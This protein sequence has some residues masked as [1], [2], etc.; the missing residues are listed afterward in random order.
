M[1]GELAAGS[2]AMNDGPVG[3]SL[4]LD[5]SQ[6]ESALSKAAGSTDRVAKLVDASFQK[7]AEKVKASTGKTGEVLKKM[8]ESALAGFTGGLAAG[9]VA[10]VL[11]K[12]GETGGQALK[13]LAYGVRTVNMEGLKMAA[14]VGA[15]NDK[16]ARA[17]K[18]DAERVTSL[19]SVSDKMKELERQIAKD[20]AKFEALASTSKYVAKQ[21]D[22]ASGIAS[23]DGWW[24]TVK[25]DYD[26]VTDRLKGDLSLMGGMMDTLRGKTGDA[27]EALA[28]LKDPL[29]NPEFTGALDKMTADWDLLLNNLDAS[30]IELGLKKL[31]QQFGATDAQMAK[32]VDRGRAFEQA[33]GLHKF[34]ES[35]EDQVKALD[36][37]PAEA[38]FAAI[39]K[40]TKLPADEA[41][42]GMER[43]RA[44]E[45]TIELTKYFDDL[46]RRAGTLDLSPAEQ[47][48]A[49][50]GYRIKLTADQMED[51][52]ERV[53]LFD[54]LAKGVELDKQFGEAMKGLDLEAKM[55]G[56]NDLQKKLLEFEAKGFGGD[57][58]AQLKARL[59][60]NAKLQAA[61]EKPE[62]ASALVAGGRDTAN[63][64]AAAQAAAMRGGVPG[65]AGQQAQAKQVEQN[66]MIVGL[67]KTLTDQGA[68]AIEVQ[69]NYEKLLREQNQKAG[70]DGGLFPIDG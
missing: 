48:F 26:K 67:L 52:L 53:R 50:L 37:S 40:A 34:F 12:I 7:T 17:N 1:A 42:W 69:R 3:V 36:F 57:Q 29:K 2:G 22:D 61:F 39:A 6:Y 60:G 31:Q 27:K 32:W 33:T 64:I 23:A 8:G 35:L 51:G 18:I 13:E 49:A 43:T 9:G 59:E 5:V 56:K 4:T 15:A 62:M 20:E 19:T 44:L 41:E 21:L 46:E 63:A 16:F 45:Q 11:T 25:G 10:G 58:L 28:R 14:W 66:N 30:P 68:K 55:I 54:K 65:G 38:Q 24:W 70:G 47:Q